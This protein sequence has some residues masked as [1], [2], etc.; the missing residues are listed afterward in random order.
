M[1]LIRIMV[2]FQ[3]TKKKYFIKEAYDA[4]MILCSP[5]KKV[6]VMIA[7]VKA[8]IRKVANAPGVEVGP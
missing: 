5:F 7:S 1:P 3:S 8:N 6:E 4:A 2:L